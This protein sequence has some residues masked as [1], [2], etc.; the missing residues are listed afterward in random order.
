MPINVLPNRHKSFADS[1]MGGIFG[2]AEAVGKQVP[3]MMASQKKLD[4][5]KKVNSYLKQLGIENPEGLPN[6]YKKSIFLDQ[7]RQS[8]KKTAPKKPLGYNDISSVF[9]NTGYDAR[10][11]EQIGA[12]G[13]DQIRQRANQYEEEGLERQ[14][15]IYKAIQEH[16][17]GGASS[18]TAAD[19]LYKNPQQQAQAD[20]T[21]AQEITNAPPEA[22]EGIMDAG[23]KGIQSSVAGRL[24][25][26]ANGVS[27]NDYQK[28]TELKNPGVVNKFA[29]EFGR[30]II[31][32][33]PFVAAGATLGAKGG[34]AAGSVAGPF[35]T[36]VGA[37]LGGGAGAL[38]LPAAL[39]TALEEYHKYK[40]N[41]GEKP[42]DAFLEGLAKTTEAGVHS[43]IQGATLSI[44]GESLPLLKQIPQLASLF[45][46][47]YLGKVAEKTA[48]GAAQATGLL[49]S[50]TLAKR[51]L[52][53]SEEVADTFAQIIG[54]NLIGGLPEKAKE[55]VM[56]R[57]KQSNLP[58]EEVANQLKD[59]LGDKPV[60]AKT[61][62]REIADITKSHQGPEKQVAESVIKTLGEIKAPE[63]KEN[64]KQLAERDIP[65][66]L[67]YE[68]RVEEAK[69]KPLTEKEQA[70]RNDAKEMADELLAEK[71]FIEDD[72]AYL[73]EQSSKGPKRQQRFSAGS[74]KG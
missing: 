49:G 4:E 48:V 64:A 41:G 14:E 50:E 68:K 59:R 60:D 31:G 8:N 19:A 37:L 20:Q 46:T 27:Y 43:G 6:E 53:T 38:A 10:A 73:E 35:G 52:P 29:K 33:S 21:F 39:D 7:L 74:F 47:P 16:I 32:N 9:R 18:E 13:I 66:A 3:E 36:G 17:K 70:K 15:A 55:T 12:E 67:A 51:K 11:I 40:S 25:A 28:Q 23:M 2:G 69:N 30:F 5:E 63:P 1:I 24:T 44:L 42:F 72:I 61:I 56:N 71:K 22:Q 57:I 65:E 58:V 62:V 54:F 45:E 26:I 34:G